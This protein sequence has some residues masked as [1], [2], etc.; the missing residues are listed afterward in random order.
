M[1]IDEIISLRN[2]RKK[3]DAKLIIYEEEL[4]KQSERLEK[5]EKLTNVI[6]FGVHSKKW[7]MLKRVC[8]AR[9]YELLSEPSSVEFIVWSRYFFRKIY[10][11]V[12]NHFEVDSTKNIHIDDYEQAKAIASFWRPSDHY[13][14]IKLAEM[15]S[16]REMGL[17]KPER[18]V[19]LNVYLKITKGG[20]INP[21]N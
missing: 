2:D 1:L 19:A 4:S 12:A 5:Q 16:K 7:S 17:L 15:I 9:V 3:Q 11:D 20:A 8:L 13:I 21:F 18:C 6:G 10:I 14:T